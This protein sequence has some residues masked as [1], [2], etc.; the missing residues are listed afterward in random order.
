[1]HVKGC[2]EVL[3]LNWKSSYICLG[4]KEDSRESC[5]ALAVSQGVGYEALT[6]LPA[7]GG[8]T[9][10]AFSPPLQTVLG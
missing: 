9:S 5:W 4:E 2:K 3:G 7:L 10:R 6:V 1:M 8:V